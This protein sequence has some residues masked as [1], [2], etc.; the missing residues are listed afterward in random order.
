MCV[1]ASYHYNFRLSSEGFYLSFQE[2]I[3][4]EREQRRTYILDTAERLFFAK[5][6]AGVSME[7]IAKEVGLN[8]ATLYLYFENKDHLLF[9]IILRRM[10]ELSAR[11]DACAVKDQNGR[12]KARL[13]GETFLAFAAENPAY[14]RTIG[15]VG[16][17]LFRDSDNPLVQRI[18]E[19]LEQQIGMLQNALA[20]G[21]VDGSVRDDLDPL[22][23]AVYISVL[24]TGIVSLPPGW[25]SLLSSGGIGFDR[26][27]ADSPL[28]I[29]RAV[30]GRTEKPEVIPAGRPGKKAGPQKK[31]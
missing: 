19:L 15:A 22:E 30:G 24:N 13:L 11:Y 29:A 25:K 31:A 26:F 1:T 7:Q 2:L 4:K 27:L 21:I 9:A 10:K 12:E 18:F 5:S 14:F 16:P 20:E 6:F 17:D 23:M 8:K 28:F 3:E